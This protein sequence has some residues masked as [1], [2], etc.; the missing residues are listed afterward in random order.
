MVVIAFIHK[1]A[2][3][4]NYFQHVDLHQHG[5]VLDLLLWWLLLKV[6]IVSEAVDIGKYQHGEISYLNM[7]T[8]G[9]L[10][11]RSLS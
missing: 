11:L 2:C 9:L 6:Y 1:S 8:F 3:W 4:D 7:V 5:W 10:P